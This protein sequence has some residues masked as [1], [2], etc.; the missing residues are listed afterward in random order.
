MYD[1]HKKIYAL[2]FLNSPLINF[3]YVISISIRYAYGFYV[4][5]MCM[6]NFIR[7]NG[8]RVWT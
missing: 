8:F 7:M 5:I 1:Q 3:I 6:S 2:F 4:L